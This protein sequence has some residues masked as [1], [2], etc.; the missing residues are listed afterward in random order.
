MQQSEVEAHGEGAEGPL[1]QGG[2]YLYEPSEARSARVIG[3]AGSPT[4]SESALSRQALRSHVDLTCS[5]APAIQALKIHLFV[6]KFLCGVCL[7]GPGA[8]Y[9]AGRS[10]TC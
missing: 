7:Q 3:R 6:Q 9:R 10:S 2:P 8:A 4:R 1:A 5:L